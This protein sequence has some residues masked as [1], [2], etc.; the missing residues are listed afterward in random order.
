MKL[1]K[2]PHEKP[3]DILALYEPT[4][5]FI[6][7]SEGVGSPYEL[8]QKAIEQHYFADVVTFLAHGLPIR[9]SIWWATICAA[10]RDD[11]NEDER[12]AISSAKSWVHSPDE[13]TRRHAEEMAKISTLN[14]G[15]GWAAQAAFWSG[16]SMTA[17]SAP[18]VP[19]PPYLYAQAVAG[20]INL[21][22][23]LPDGARAKERYKFFLE[24]GLDLAIGGN[25]KI[26]GN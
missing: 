19:P 20:C 10:S 1:L 13:T 21:T 16:G 5:E 2:I 17:I 3:V 4:P 15:A 8:I 14:S 9:E 7:L 25:G 12:N 23:V 11:W 18:V 6:E 24:I 22:A 26:E